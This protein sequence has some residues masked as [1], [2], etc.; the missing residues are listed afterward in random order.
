MGHCAP[1]WFWETKGQASQKYDELAEMDKRLAEMDLDLAKFD[2][3][4]TD[5]LKRVET[6]AP[7]IDKIAYISDENNEQA[8]ELVKDTSGRLDEYREEGQS[9]GSSNFNLMGMVTSLATGDYGGVLLTLLAS[10][11]LGGAGVNKYRKT[12]KDL[13][14]LSEM[15]PEIAKQEKVKRGYA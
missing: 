1:S 10:L 3:R 2:K 12:I 6:L 15:D 8:I 5:A 7:I 11:G 14:E 13:D 4:I 9:L